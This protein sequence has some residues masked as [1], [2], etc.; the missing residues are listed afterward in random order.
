MLHG[1][2]QQSSTAAEQSCGLR[3]DDGAVFHFDG[4][5]VVAT[6]N[7]TLVGGDGD[8]SGGRR[9][10][11]LV[12]QQT[13][14][15]HLAFVVGTVC[16]L[17]RSIVEAAD[18]LVAR[19]LAAHLVVADAEAHH[20]DTHIGG[21]LV[22]VLAV[23][24]F[25][26]GIQHGEDFYI[27]VVVDGGLAVG[28]QVEGV[29]H[30]H[31]VEVGGSS[32]VGDVHGML[33]RQVPDGEGLELRVAGTDAPLVLVVELRQTGCH[34]AATRSG[35]G[36][37]DERTRGLHIVVLA[38]SL[39]AGDEFHI[40]RIAVDGVVDVALDAHS[41]QAVAE[42]VG[43]MLAVVVGDDDRAHHEV[44]AH[45]LVAQ[46]EH[47]LVVGDAEVGAHLVLLHVFRVHHDDDLY[48]LAQ[49]SE[50]AELRVGLEAR[51]YARGVVVV[52]E[53]SAELHV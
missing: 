9:D 13:N 39:V 6:L 42:L 31:V 28:F 33:Q 43:G 41:L 18:D 2:Q 32:L 12:E 5:R 24:A 1:V 44:A 20:V 53:L 45:E 52:E 10:L 36:D 21:R 17:V 49:L 40:V 23:D 30:V 15:V 3:G 38:E 22:G 51:Q 14:L 8:L 35:S 7:L 50:H 48:A 37:D 26:E 47:I 29:D 11:C 4:C 25:E 34:L 27:A 46:A 16:H 19:C